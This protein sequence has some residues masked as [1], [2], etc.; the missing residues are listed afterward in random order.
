LIPVYRRIRQR[1]NQ[2]I[3]QL[4]TTSRRPVPAR[5]I[6]QTVL[7]AVQN[8]IDDYESLPP[9][10]CFV[11]TT[12]DDLIPFYQNTLDYLMNQSF[13][14]APLDAQQKAL[15]TRVGVL[16]L[17]RDRF[18]DVLSGLVFAGFGNAETFPSLISYHIDG[19]V[20]GKLKKKAIDD[21][22][23]GR[24]TISARIIPFAQRDIVDR[25]LVGIDPDLESEILRY[26]KSAKDRTESNIFDGLPRLGQKNKQKI[27]DNLAK[28]LGVAVSDFESTWIRGA[29]DTY[30]QQTN[31]MVLFMAKQELAQL[32]EA[33]VN[34]TSLKRKFSAEE[35]TVAGPIDVA[36]ISKGDGFVWVKRKHYF[37]SELNARYFLRKFGIHGPRPGGNHAS[38]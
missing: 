22:R 9:A 12:E 10:E 24:D 27:L 4:L 31:D 16:A 21:E 17:H 32:A 28:S 14:G 1:F 25:F 13:A 18:S 8:V 15:L 29:K 36:V 3:N 35:E 33:L 6:S 37:P 20:G 11:G 5:Y 19:M 2:Q 38:P 23:T 26:M 7:D 34:I 30:Q